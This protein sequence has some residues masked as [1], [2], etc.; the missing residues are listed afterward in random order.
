M[1]AV[2]GI[3]DRLKHEQKDIVIK[4]LQQRLDNI[5]TEVLKLGITGRS[6]MGK[7]SFI[8]LILDLSP[9]D[10]DYAV[11]GAGDTTLNVKLYR[12]PKNNQFTI[13]DMPGFGTLEMP[14]DKFLNIVNIDDYDFFF[15]FIDT[16]LMEDDLWIAKQ[17]CERKVPF[18]FVR[19][20]LDLY[21]NEENAKGID[22]DKAIK[23]LR[24]KI[25]ATLNKTD[26]LKECKLF[27]ISNLKT[28]FHLGDLPQL[29]SFMEKSMTGC[30]AE[31]FLFFLPI[32]TQETV[33][34]KY[35]KLKTRV[36]L[37]SILAG[38][39]GAIPIPGVD[40]VV[41]LVILSNELKRYVRGFKLDKD[42]V[43]TVPGITHPLSLRNVLSLNNL[44]A[45][46]NSGIKSL[47][48]IGVIV[49]ASQLDIIIP[50][51]GS[52][53]SAGVNVKVSCNFLMQ[54]LK[55]LKN[56]ALTVHHHFMSSK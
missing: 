47:L 7:S 31:T 39:M 45:F 5:D 32:L 29:F 9:D 17:L 41:N 13:S 50:V 33:E 24:E 30:K 36:V 10:P 43:P 35:N 28:Y 16:V 52:V 38:L 12:H 23:N 20:K 6:A 53:L 18:C 1:F 49:A 19:A 51:V 37:T 4:E 8:N 21:V 34:L 11:T 40:I 25:T 46:V 22:K 56:D 3:I 27:L 14:K 15:I 55:E 48:S 42:Y 2:G 54:N 26:L 44:K